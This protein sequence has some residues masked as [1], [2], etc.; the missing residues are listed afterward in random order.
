[1][2]MYVVILSQSAS[3]FNQNAMVHKYHF[4]AFYRL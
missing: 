1:M 3:D 4:A 2:I